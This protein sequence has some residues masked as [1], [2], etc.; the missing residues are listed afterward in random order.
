MR[1]RVMSGARAAAREALMRACALHYPLYTAIAVG[2][3]A[4]VAALRGEVRLAARLRGFVD[5]VYRTEGVK[6]EPTER[7]ADGILMTALRAALSE[8]DFDRLT[9]RGALLTEDEAVELSLRWGEPRRRKVESACSPADEPVGD[10][11]A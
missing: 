7:R 9:A 2:H 6:R 4:T 3:I 11:I 10:S 5:E 1:M 8:A